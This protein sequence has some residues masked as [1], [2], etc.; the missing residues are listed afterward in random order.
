MVVKNP[1]LRALLIALGFVSVATAV[2]GLFLPVIP[3][4]G[5]VLLAGFAFSRSS[6]RF[7]AWLVN[8]RW[9]GPIICDWR[10]GL[11][12]SMRAKVIAVVA[13]IASFTFTLTKAITNTGGRMAM[14]VLALA[15][16]AYVVSRPTKPPE[17]SDLINP[18]LALDPAE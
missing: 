9:F 2:A 1:V 5:P 17:A 15:I 4:T 6:E 13:I 10:A 3:T 14:I 12:F 8:H 11:G 18:E 16:S 7:D